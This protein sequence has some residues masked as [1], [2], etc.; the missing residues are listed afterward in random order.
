[1]QMTG[2]QILMECLLEQKVDTIFGYPGGAI[3]NVYDEI[4]KQ[5]NRKNCALLPSVAIDK[6]IGELEE[7]E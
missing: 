1:M 6:M 3:L 4:Y 7:N 5:P 2:S